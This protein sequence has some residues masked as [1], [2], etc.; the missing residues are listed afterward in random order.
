MV[1]NIAILWDQLLEAFT[2]MEQDKVYFLDRMTGEIFFVSSDQGELLWEQIE[3]QQARF[4]EIPAFDHLAERKLLN[5]F[6]KSNNNAELAL[7]LEYSLSGKAPYASSADI[8]S[9]FPE[10]EDRIAEMKDSFLSNRVKTW[11]E[12]NELF[13]TTVPT[14]PAN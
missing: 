13:S 14:N 10:E 11:L 8:L 9:F 12:E 4:I 7:L 5:S 2:N 1:R 3:Q 6:V